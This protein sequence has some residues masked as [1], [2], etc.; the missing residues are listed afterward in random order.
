MF[1]ND[2]RRFVNDSNVFV[3]NERVFVCSETAF[4]C[5]ERRRKK[6]QKN[7]THS[8]AE[9]TTQ[10]EFPCFDMVRHTSQCTNA[11]SIVAIYSCGHGAFARTIF[12]RRT[13]DTELNRNGIKAVSL[14][15]C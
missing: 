11:I 2:E 8:Y 7:M 12:H 6:I 13:V 9:M 15:S 4:V 3:C 1:V 10:D 14:L 5:N